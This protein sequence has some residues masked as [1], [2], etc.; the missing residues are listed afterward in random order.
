AECQ[1]VAAADPQDI[2]H[3]GGDGTGYFVGPGFKNEIDDRFSKTIRSKEACK[4]R[5]KDQKREKR[6]DRADRE[7]TGHGP[8]IV[9]VK[10]PEGIANDSPDRIK[11]AAALL[12]FFH[13]HQ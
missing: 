9:I 7:V 2:V 4:S 3:L 1:H 10:M 6:H 8:A 12:L 13:A 5:G 11:S